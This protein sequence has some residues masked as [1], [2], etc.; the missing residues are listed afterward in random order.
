M[1]NYLCIYLFMNNRSLKSSIQKNTNLLP[2]L[3]E[4]VNKYAKSIPFKYQQLQ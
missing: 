4:I 2:N 3:V 1:M